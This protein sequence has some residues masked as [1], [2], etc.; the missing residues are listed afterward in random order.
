MDHNNRTT[1]FTDPRLNSQVLNALLQKQPRPSTATT[2]VPSSPP[3][4]TTVSVNPSV[5]TTNTTSVATPV[6]T[7]STTVAVNNRNNTQTSESN[8]RSPRPVIVSSTIVS[9]PAV[10]PTTDSTPAESPPNSQE[11][12]D[13]IPKFRRD[14]AS[15][16]KVLKTEL[17]AMQPQ[18]GHCRLEVCVL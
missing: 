14:L 12:G 17:L 6:S 5:A 18:S 16:L 7:I 15:K 11:S 2:A 9:T 8:T 4:L 1:Q 13:F 3:S 10:I